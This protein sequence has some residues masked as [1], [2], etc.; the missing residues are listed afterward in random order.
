MDFNFCSIYRLSA[1]GA[2]SGS[3][4]AGSVVGGSP[5]AGSHTTPSAGFMKATG[6]V[7]RRAVV[8]G[9]LR[10][11]FRRAVG[12]GSKRSTRVVSKNL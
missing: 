2:G 12:A 9:S 4:V 10:T 1:Y 5:G 3:L 11:S 7:S 6:A 8:A